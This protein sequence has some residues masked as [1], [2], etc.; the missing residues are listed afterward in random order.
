MK[1]RAGDLTPRSR[2]ARNEFARQLRKFLSDQKMR[3]SKKAAQEFAAY[4][5]VSRGTLYR[6]ADSTEERDKRLAEIIAL[7]GSDSETL[8]GLS[9]PY[10]EVAA[11]EGVHAGAYQAAANLGAPLR[12][13]WPMRCRR[14]NRPPTPAPPR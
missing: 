6:D 13:R 10:L 12:A 9:A 1:A 2:Q 8:Y 3:V 14:R 4:Q 11:K 5:K 7:L